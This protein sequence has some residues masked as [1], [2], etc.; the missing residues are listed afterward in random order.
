MSYRGNFCSRLQ[1]S[2]Y[3]CVFKYVRAVTKR[4]GT[5]LKKES[6]T[7]NAL[8]GVWG[9]RLLRHALPI[10][11]LILRKK[12]DCFA[13]YFCSWEK[14]A[15]KKKRLVRDTLRRSIAEVKGSN[16][17]VCARNPAMVWPFKWEPLSSSFLWSCLLCCTSLN[18][19]GFLFAYVNVVSNWNCDDL[20]SRKVHYV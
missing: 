3:I 1:N 8:T 19:S 4:S 14:K 17:G 5:R 15:R 18:C 13:V 10:S 16:F 6:E 20:L 9:S 11:L 7:V 2:P 12:T